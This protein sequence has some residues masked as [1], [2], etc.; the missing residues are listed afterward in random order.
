MEGLNLLD[1]RNVSWNLL[2]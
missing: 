2:H 1:K